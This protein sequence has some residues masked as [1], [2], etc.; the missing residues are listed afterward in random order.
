[1]A[2]ACS[3]FLVTVATLDKTAY[4]YIADKH[5]ACISISQ[6]LWRRI[7]RPCSPGPAVI[8]IHTKG[9]RAKVQSG[10]AGQ[11]MRNFKC[12]YWLIWICAL[13]QMAASVSACLRRS[14]FFICETAAE[15][16]WSKTPM[17]CLVCA[18]FL[19]RWAQPSNKEQFQHCSPL[20]LLSCVSHLS[21]PNRERDGNQDEYI[22]YQ[23]RPGVWHGDGELNGSE[24]H[25]HIS[26]ALPDSCWVFLDGC[27]YIYISWAGHRR[28]SCCFLWSH[29]PV[30]SLKIG[31]S[32]VEHESKRMRAARFLKKFECMATGPLQLLNK[33]LITLLIHSLMTRVVPPG[34]P[35]ALNLL[36]H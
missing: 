6:P 21:S 27:D 2:K 16:F 22:C 19:V 13:M 35:N 9:E 26:E 34:W 8:T 30:P 18:L 29:A 32:S 17:W 12:G 28:R 10:A 1:M 3:P 5:G 14:Q 20:S 24:Q 7:T 23:L 36:L 15:R 25:R 31:S 33:W 11:L 4:K